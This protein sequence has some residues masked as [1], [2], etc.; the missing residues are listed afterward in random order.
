[1]KKLIL[2]FFISIVSYSQTDINKLKLENSN[3]KA[4]LKI[5]KDENDYLKKVFKINHP[6]K[7]LVEGNNSYK[8]TSVVK[9]KDFLKFSVLIESIDEDKRLTIGDFQLVDLEG[10]YYKIDLSNTGDIY[11]KLVKEVPY[12]L[13]LSFKVGDVKPLFIK[14]LQFKISSQPE[15]NL[16]E[17]QTHSVFFKDL[18]I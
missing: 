2:F 3:L 15:R 16:F 12:K 6:I 18:K 14:L 13:E 10:N 7:E 9:E 1:M 4:E 8:I 11:P 17:N 5:Y